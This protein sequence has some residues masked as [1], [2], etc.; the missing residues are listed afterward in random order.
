MEKPKEKSIPII[1]LIDFLATR[2][3]VT[4]GTERQVIEIIKNINRDRFEPI[5]ICL[6]EFVTSDLWDK[7]DCEKKLLHIY[8]MFS[9]SGIIG[10]LNFI[11]FLKKRRVRIIQTYFFDSTIFGVL[12]AKFAGVQVILSARRDL[13]FWYDKQIVRKLKFVNRFT[14]RILVNSKAIKY[15]LHNVENF[16]L[17]GIDVL[18]NG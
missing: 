8:S 1:F 3:G 14:F 6:Q 13:G 7:I 18:Y 17:K 16:P 10:F 15:T 9:F 4:G 5:L 2:E 11:Y 12:A